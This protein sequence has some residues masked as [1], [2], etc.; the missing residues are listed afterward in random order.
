MQEADYAA[1]AQIAYTF[2]DTDDPLAKPV[3]EALQVIDEAFDSWGQDHISLS[4]NGGKDCTVLLH[5]VAAS[6]GRRSHT[7][8]PPKPLAAVYIP[9]PSPFPQLEAFI[10]EAAK[11]YHLN[12]FHCPHPTGPNFP[13]E[14]VATPGSVNAPVKDLPQNVRGGEGMRRALELY[15]ARFPHIEA[16]LIGTRRGDPHGATLGFRN[17]TDPG[18]PQFVR[19][20]PIINWSYADVWAYL[21]K[22]DVPYC[23]LYDQGYTSL[24]STYNTFPN[25]ALRVYPDQ[26]CTR[27]AQSPRRNGVAPSA[28][29]AGTSKTVSAPITNGHPAPRGTKLTQTLPDS[30][31]TI[32]HGDPFTICTGDPQP[33]GSSLPHVSLLTNLTGTPGQVCEGEAYV[34]DGPRSARTYGDASRGGAR[35]ERAME[36]RARESTAG[37]GSQCQ[38][39]ARYRPAYE[40]LD[41]ALERAGRAGG[42]VPSGPG[43]A[44]VAAAT[45][46][47]AGV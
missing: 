43:S 3:K 33:S 10:K 32:L 34:P 42:A 2:A 1:I 8:R 4:F 39:G 40:L 45:T 19:V 7:N 31:T 20:N 22:F 30:F 18:W 35:A 27:C 9:V 46:T 28:N 21:K 16:I 25:P 14:T 24:G 36:G 41:G 15:K 6:L 47:L 23:S 12:L 38:C 29:G 17:L 26:P 5:L 37:D 11:A 44:A 13:V